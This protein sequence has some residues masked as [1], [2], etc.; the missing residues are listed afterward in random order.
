MPNPNGQERRSHP[1]CLKESEW[2]ELHEY[3]RNQTETLVRMEKKQAQILEKIFGN[4]SEGLVVRAALNK[5]AISRV[6]W[7][8]GGVSS[9]I[10]AI[11]LFLGGAHLMGG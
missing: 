1:E 8:L 11:A 6:W 9:A 2:G 3:M 4:G 7:W 5:Q 10:G